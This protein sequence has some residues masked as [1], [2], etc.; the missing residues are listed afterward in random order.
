MIKF[1]DNT[2]ELKPYVPGRPIEDVKKEYNL[3][4]VIKLASNENP[5]GCSQ[6]VT[7]AINESVNLIKYY[8]DGYCTDL[9]LKISTELNI[10]KD[11]LIFGCGTDELI[12]LLSRALINTS[13]NAITAEITFGQYAASVKSAGGHMILSKMK[14]NGFDLDDIASK[15]D[16]KTKIIFLANPNNPTGTMFNDKALTS[17]LEKV[18]SN[19][20]VVM[21]EAYAE[22][23]QA[24]DY[25]NTLSLM[26]K[27][28]NLV[29][30]KTF[31][32]AYGLA[33][34]RVGY[35]I[36]SKYIISNLEKIRNP[37]NVNVVAHAAASA[38]FGDK[39]FLDKTI[40][41]NNK[42]LKYLISELKKLDLPYIDTHTN[43]IMIDTKQ[44][45]DVVFKKLMAKG[46][47]VRPGSLFKMGNYIRLSIG[48]FDDMIAFV[49]ALKEVL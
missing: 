31:S 25:P 27:Y 41:N 21:D 42:A 1:S 48:L 11:N 32:K 36:A 22:F 10:D 30:F 34:L 26:P 37:F 3:K 46:F 33:G 47:I 19:V 20:V 35:G 28:E 15:I 17:F 38:A 44:D 16:S 29:L 49:C 43:F 23:V 4:N 39:E 45:G 12:T 5:F 2:K 7:N 18:P 13:D 9:R 40:D 6:K 8:P 14:D 24:K